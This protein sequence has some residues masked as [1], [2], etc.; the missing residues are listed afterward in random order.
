MTLTGASVVVTA[1][2][3]G[4]WAQ[5]IGVPE[6][7]IDFLGDKAGIRLNYGGNF[8][9]WGTK[10]GQL[11]QDTPEYESVHMFQEEID[12][13]VRCVQTGERNPA[14][15]DQAIITARMMQAIY[16]SSEQKREITLEW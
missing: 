7:Y 16:D 5:N 6:M 15:I 11:W 3:N 10:D 14:H 2:L 8:T 13:F 4:A 12:S 9:I 1:V